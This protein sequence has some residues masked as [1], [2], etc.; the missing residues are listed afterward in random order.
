MNEFDSGRLVFILEGN[1]FI[2]TENINYADMVII[3]TCSVRKK[4]ENRLYGHIGNLKI[5]KNKN[6]D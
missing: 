2:R 1:G 5:L 3:N 4:A 6:P